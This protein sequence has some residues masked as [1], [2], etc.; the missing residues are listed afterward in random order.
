MAISTAKYFSSN[1]IWS[2]GVNI[3]GHLW[4]RK[5]DTCGIGV[6]Q[7][8]S[9]SEMRKALDRKG[10]HEDHVEAYYNFYINPYLS[11]T[12]GFQLIRNPYGADVPNSSENISVYY[13]R[14]H[15]DF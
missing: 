4:E 1:Y 3:K 13:L 9:P 5:K 12:P 14:A 15:V 6:G 11:V 10:R 7:I 8:L 2:T